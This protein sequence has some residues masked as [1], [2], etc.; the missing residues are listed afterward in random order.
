MWLWR[1]K[2]NTPGYQ[3]EA[4]RW[5]TSAV[6]AQNGVPQQL[7]ETTWFWPTLTAK[8]W[9]CALSERFLRR[10]AFL[11][12]QTCSKIE[13]ATS[14]YFYLMKKSLVLCGSPL[15]I[16]NHSDRAHRVVHSSPCCMFHASLCTIQSKKFCNESVTCC[17]WRWHHHASG[18]RHFSLG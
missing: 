7:F 14:S 11:F 9:M 18:Y 16:K 12:W 1:H 2:N 13:L 15:F 10:E 4:E 3:W 8:R 5:W 6:S 17:A